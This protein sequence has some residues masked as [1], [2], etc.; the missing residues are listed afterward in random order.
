MA[1]ETGPA[2]RDLIWRP[3]RRPVTLIEVQNELEPLV[4]PSGYGPVFTGPTAGTPYLVHVGDCFAMACE[5][6]ATRPTAG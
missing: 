4:C 3:A 2:G 5:R 6:A 1:R